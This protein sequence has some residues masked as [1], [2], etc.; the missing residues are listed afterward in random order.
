MLCIFENI[1]KNGCHH[2][3]DD[4]KSDIQVVLISKQSQ[5]YFSEVDILV[6]VD[7]LG[8]VVCYKGSAHPANLELEGVFHEG[9]SDQVVILP[10]KAFEV[11]SQF[12]DWI[13]LIEFPIFYVVSNGTGCSRLDFKDKGIS[14]LIN[15]SAI[16]LRPK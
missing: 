10:F 6:A 9:S 7:I 4:L 15:I 5:D 12:I 8:V 1:V 13:I 11:A 14:I 2:F 3:G 16:N